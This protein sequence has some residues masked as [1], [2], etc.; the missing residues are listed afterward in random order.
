MNWIPLDHEQSFSPLHTFQGKYVDKS[1][2]KAMTRSLGCSDDEVLELLDGMITVIPKRGSTTFLRHDH[3]RSR[4][5]S[6]MTG[7]AQPYTVATWLTEPLTINDVNWRPWLNNENG[8]IKVNDPSDVFDAL[9]LPRARAMM[10][11]LYAR[12]SRSLSLSKSNATTMASSTSTAADAHLYNV[13]GHLRH[14]CQPLVR[15]GK[16]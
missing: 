3:W 1:L 4:A 10:R 13:A 14:I 12:C 6:A 11:Q 8:T 15:L 16:I 9:F 2:R 7:L 5:I